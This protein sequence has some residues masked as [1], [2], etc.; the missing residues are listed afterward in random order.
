MPSLLEQN[1]ETA[2]RDS[3]ILKEW[4][5]L[6]PKDRGDYMRPMFEIKNDLKAIKKLTEII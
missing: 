2:E 3:M 1:E 5:H 4:A 6:G